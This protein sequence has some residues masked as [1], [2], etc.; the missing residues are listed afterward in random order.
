LDLVLLDVH[1]PDMSG[2]DLLRRIQAAG[3]P[4]DVIAVTQAR[5]LPVVQAALTFGAMQYLMM[6]FTFAAVRQ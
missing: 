2:L 3:N 1:L 6:P 5:D 4:V